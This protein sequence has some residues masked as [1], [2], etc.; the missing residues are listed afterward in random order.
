MKFYDLKYFLRHQIKF[1][2]GTYF[3]QPITIMT[4]LTNNGHTTKQMISNKIKI[5]YNR[6]VELNPNHYVYKV[7]EKHKIIYVD[8]DDVKFIDYNEYDEDQKKIIADICNQIIRGSQYEMKTIEEHCFEFH[9]WSNRTININYEE[10]IK[11][12]RKKLLEIINQFENKNVDVNP[13][14]YYVNRLIIEDMQLDYFIN[15]YR[16]KILE[17]IVKY[18]KTKDILK[19]IHANKKND[20]YID[21]K[22][23]TP[24][25]F[26][27]G[28]DNPI[29]NNTLNVAYDE[30]AKIFG[31]NYTLTS[32]LNDYEKDR[33]CWMKLLEKMKTYD[34]KNIH[35]L[36]V[37]CYW[38]KVFIKTV[39]QNPDEWKIL[40]FP[41]Y[42]KTFEFKKLRKKE[43]LV[44]LL[45]M[46]G[47]KNLIYN[48]ESINLFNFLIGSVKS[49]FISRN[50]ID[51]I[52][53][54]KFSYFS[55]TIM[56]T[57]ENKNY[58]NFSEYLNTVSEGLINFL[59]SAIKLDI[60][61]RGSV[62]YGE[63]ITN[64]IVSGGSAIA[65][66][67]SC[68]ELANWIGITATPSLYNKIIKDADKNTPL[69]FIEYDIPTKKGIEIGYALNLKKLFTPQSDELENLIRHLDTQ[70]DKHNDYDIS[71]KYR[72][73]IKFIKSD[74]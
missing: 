52:K 24:I 32:K 69:L 60:F 20:S 48:D 45:D 68:Y 7:L 67:G 65:E 59:L 14:E 66:A 33:K 50:N 11:T 57:I 74:L 21:P 42:D 12:N 49:K 28:D 40:N 53:S 62:S 73:T 6:T 71:I 23:I 9:Y 39:V 34:I 61:L 27:I 54:A 29:I 25:F 3:H 19:I 30:L 8:E 41:E 70:R 5:R 16:E 35:E 63:Y 10:R 44:I 18:K 46:L 56:I 43:G 58:K 36:Q 64:E 4:I 1:G 22:Y 13:I 15:G 51:I 38:R 31:L 26:Y 2:G 55:D 47:T 17:F 37:F 72:N